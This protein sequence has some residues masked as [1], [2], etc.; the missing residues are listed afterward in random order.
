MLRT[1]GLDVDLDSLNLDGS[2]TRCA[3]LVNQ[4]TKKTVLYC[5][6]RFPRKCLVQELPDWRVRFLGFCCGHHWTE[7]DRRSFEKH[8]EA[9]RQAR[10]AADLKKQ[11]KAAVIAEKYYNGACSDSAF[12]KQHGYAQSKLVEFG[13]EVRRGNGRSVIGRMLY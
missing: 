9:Q 13:P 10:Y 3:Q 7:K 1:K 2:L 6:S 8:V 11:R 4:I 5:T 12:V